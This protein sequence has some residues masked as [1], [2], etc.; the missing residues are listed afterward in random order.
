MLCLKTLSRRKCVYVF[1]P[2][3]QSVRRCRH[4]SIFHFTLLISL[5]LLSFLSRCT[6]ESCRRHA[7]YENKEM[8]IGT[9]KN[10]AVR[11]TVHLSLPQTKCKRT[12]SKHLI[13]AR[14]EIPQ[15]KH[16]CNYFDA[17]MFLLYFLSSFT[18]TSLSPPL[19]I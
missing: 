9:G 12:T 11:V 1:N 8:G 18:S 14:R 2:L 7:Y 5:F 16:A 10:G 4:F 13:M 6:T 17:N 15:I 3:E 19:L